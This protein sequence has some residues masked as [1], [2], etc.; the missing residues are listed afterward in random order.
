MKGS[1]LR[2]C[3]PSQASLV[4]SSHASV[5]DPNRSGYLGRVI[6]EAYGSWP[7][8][9]V[10]ALL[11]GGPGMSVTKPSGAAGQRQRA[12]ELRD[13][14]DLLASALRTIGAGRISPSPVPV[15]AAGAAAAVAMHDASLIGRAF[16]EFWGDGRLS[17]AAETNRSMPTA[18]HVS[19]AL[20]CIRSA[21]S[22]LEDRIAALTAGRGRGA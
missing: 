12:N 5:L 6:V 8:D 19:F 22:S 1:S 21:Q 11:F 14:V 7:D 3:R 13:V 4:L 10:V 18:L 16:F 2:G 20:D 15:E 9:Y 17:F